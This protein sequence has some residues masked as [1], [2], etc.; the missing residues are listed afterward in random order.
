M[1]C[2]RN[3]S[4]LLIL[5]YLYS[6]AYAQKGEW[7]TGISLSPGIAI[8]HLDAIEDN[9]NAG[10][11]IFVQYQLT[12]RFGLLL[13]PSFRHFTKYQQHLICMNF[14][15]ATQYNNLETSFGIN[16]RLFHQTSTNLRG[17]LT[18]GYSFQKGLFQNIRNYYSHEIFF[19]SRFHRHFINGHAPFLALD[20]R[21]AIGGRYGISWGVQYTH[22]VP[23]KF[24]HPSTEPMLLLNVR[25]GRHFN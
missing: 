23:E 16:Y 2:F 14:C 24:E 1:L 9:W 5:F 10:A 22:P 12:D 8:H 11:G 7:Y 19:T 17:Y 21:H 6:N 18:L 3:L 13:N 20:M 4:A 25:I 15:G